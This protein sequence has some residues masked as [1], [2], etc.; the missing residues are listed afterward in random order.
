MVPA[1]DSRIELNWVPNID[2]IVTGNAGALCVSSEEKRGGI[3]RALVDMLN[4]LSAALV[5]RAPPTVD[6]RDGGNERDGGRE[7]RDIDDDMDVDLGCSLSRGNI[8]YARVHGSAYVG[9]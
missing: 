2:G 9:G 3:G 4:D 5:C 6:G 7:P 1:G 8:G